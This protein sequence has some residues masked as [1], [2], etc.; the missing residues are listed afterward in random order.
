MGD[1][2]NCMD[3]FKNFGGIGQQSMNHT[4]YINYKFQKRSREYILSKMRL[5]MNMK[6]VRGEVYL[7][8]ILKKVDLSRDILILDIQLGK[9]V[10]MDSEFNMNQLPASYRY[11]D[12]ILRIVQK[13]IK[14]SRRTFFLVQ[15]QIASMFHHQSVPRQIM[16]K[17]GLKEDEDNKMFTLKQKKVDNVQRKEINYNKSPHVRQMQRSCYVK[18]DDEVL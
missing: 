6:I 10:F 9:E 14:P 3:I 17:V 2:N 1:K 8:C 4:Q 12:P 13:K 16:K 7:D 15:K 11:Y 18:I 5:F